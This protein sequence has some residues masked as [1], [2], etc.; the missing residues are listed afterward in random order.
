MKVIVL[1]FLC[2][3]YIMASQNAVAQ[4]TINIDTLK[5]NAPIKAFNQKQFVAASIQGGIIT[6]TMI[7]LN[8]YWYAQYPKRKFGS[9]DDS[10]EW[11]QM[12]K[13]GHVFSAYLGSRLSA[14]IWKSAEINDTKSAW[15]GGLCGM[16]YQTA[17]EVMDGYSAEYGFSW[18]DIAGNTLGATMFITQ[19]VAWQQQRIQPKLSYTTQQYETSLQPRIKDLYGNTKQERLLKDYTK[20]IRLPI[21]VF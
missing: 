4:N 21:V 15:L 18:A 14:E 6:S 5:K 7:V 17:F 1:F 8:K 11:Q 3:A 20:P 10:K 16:L 12:D 9:F 19:Q 13:M 2:G